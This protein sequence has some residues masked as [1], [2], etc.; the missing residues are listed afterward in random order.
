MNDAD[1]QSIDGRFLQ[2][3]EAAPSAPR[4]AGCQM[5]LPVGARFCLNCGQPVTGR[6]P[7]A[8]THFIPLA[9][10]APPPL[11]EKVR[12]AAYL[13][14]ERR[15]VTAVYVDVVGSTGLAGQL[16]SAGWSAVLDKMC[17]WF[18]PIIYR[19]E[20]TIARFV[21]DE[22]LAFFGAP[23]AHED[24]PVRAVRAALQILDTVAQGAATIRRKFGVDF[25]VRISVSTGPVTIGPVGRDLQF[26]YS[27]LEGSLNLA[28]QLEA[29]KRSMAVLIS[30]ETYR[31][32]APFF[33]CID[34]G[35]AAVEGRTETPAAA[36]APAEQGVH[37]YQVHAE[38]SRSVSG[39]GAHT[40]QLG[41]LEGNESPLVE[42]ESE[43]QSLLQLTEAVTAGL[44]RAVVIMGESGL[45]KTRLVAE[46]K[47]AVA[48]TTPVSMNRPN[49][50]LQWA[51]GHCL[52]Y[53]QGTAYHL[54]RDL[55]RSLIG[56]SAAAN[57][58][59]TRAALHALSKQLFGD[60][61]LDVYPYLGHL[62]SL[63]L[64][65]EA[66]QRILPLDPPELQAQYLAALKR[67]LVALAAAGPIVLL[68]EDLQWADPSS[69]AILSQLLPLAATT[70]LLFCL[71][72]TPHG[73]TAG[74]RLVTASR[75]TL[76]GRFIELR[77]NLLSEAGSR[78]MISN[79]LQI[80]AAPGAE[81]FVARWNLVLKKAEGNPLFIEEVLR[82]MI[83]R[84]AI[85]RRNGG[86]T[87]AGE[88]SALGIPDNLHGL[89]LARLDRLPDDARQTLRIA[90]VIGRRFPVRVLEQVL[91]SGQGETP[92]TARLIGYLGDLESSGLIDVFQI[93][94]ELIYRFHNTLLREA[95]YESLLP[96]DRQR[97]HL[98]VGEAMER[99]HPESLQQIAVQLAQHFLIGGDKVRALNYFSLAG[100]A[101]LN[102][103]ANQEAVSRYRQALDLLAPGH[104]TPLYGPSPQ[105]ANLLD[106]L[107]LALFWQG[108][109]QDA[110]QVWH[111]G[112]AL[113][114]EL[115]D[116][117]GV[118][119]LYARSARAAWSAG[120]TPGG[121]SLCQEALAALLPV[122]A[123]DGAPQNPG[124][125][126]LLHEAARAY[127]FNG[128][129]AEARRL[130]QQALE[131]AEYLGDISVQA[132]ALATLGLLSDQPPEEALDA[133]SKAAEL[134]ESTGLLSQAARAHVNLAALMATAMPDFAAARD[135]YQRAAEL[136]R[137]RGN[138]AG[139]LLALGGMTGVL[140]ESGDLQEAEATLLA[141]RKLLP[142]APL[143]P[144]ADKL[145]ADP[146]PAGF[147]FLFNEALL[148]RY[149]G[150]F[151]EAAQMLHALQTGERRRG[152]LQN[153]VDV[154]VHLAELLLESHILPDLAILGE[155]SDAE[156]T[157][158]EAVEICDRWSTC[159]TRA[160]S[161]LSM[162]YT[163]QGRYADA[164]RLLSET[165]DK[166]GTHP[167]AFDEGWPFLAE[168]RLAAAEARWPQALALFASVAEV[169]G[170]LGM[171]W[172]R[173]RVL[174]AWAEAHISRR[175]PTDVEQARTLLQ[176]AFSLFSMM[177]ASYYTNLVKDRLR[178]LEIESYAQALAHQKVDQEMAAA[179]KIQSGFLPAM[180]PRIPGWQLAAVLV[181]SRQTSGDFYDFIPL[182]DGRL[183][184]VIADVADKGASAA[185]FTAL[186]ISLIRTYAAGYENR[187]DL[188]LA[189]TNRRILADTHTD[190]FVT[191]FY[192]VLD[193][194][195][196]A[197]LYSNAGH[198]PP[199]HFLGSIDPLKSAAAG[200][201]AAQPLARTGIPVGIL[202]DTT[203]E[204]KT[205]QLTA[206]DVL[207]LYTDGVTDAQDGQGAFFSSERLLATVNA[208]TSGSE[209][210]QSHIDGQPAKASA[211]EIQEAILTA[212]HQFS[213]GVPQ[214]DDIALVVLRRTPS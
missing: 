27:A 135:H 157:L 52:S 194:L 201:S 45:G 112:I 162:V 129:Q 106:K 25:A 54:L 13:T 76:G 210:A 124:M 62:L 182:S 178:T 110:L 59:E 33:D 84:G 90:A 183:G 207:V 117:D 51:E 53:S 55:L 199:Y 128:L 160:R 103:Y 39:A 102:A 81:D 21:D 9:A 165:W 12:A 196:G 213:G 212:I 50:S 167:F 187:P 79:L 134:A 41:G 214:F 203:W 176:E 121:L 19:Y 145:V 42:R 147:H 16:G 154:N 78:Q 198:N 179:G 23:V 113:F 48:Q 37:I 58:P 153:L 83:D 136:H 87:T 142:E 4:C 10:A 114:Q 202:T 46:W 30:E 140:L 5:L 200:S 105:H 28:A 2:D 161:F 143:L 192:G 31:L 44:G 125:A 186:S 133:L 93:K 146:G 155:W 68:L 15:L 43:L 49:P 35:P 70:P 60:L 97:L 205:V 100:D 190:L 71:V 75:E 98:A 72:I 67:L 211:Q 34:I 152:N 148:R 6:T 171:R 138:T 61:F 89:L 91:G 209:A 94:P 119:R 208:V 180:P 82:M 88:I 151:V 137:L 36:G 29:T 17:D 166:A 77:L 195:S 130:G 99:L 156:A 66:A 92:T 65:D 206:G 188:V 108:H 177:D 144:E 174:L 74:W 181:P 173:A 63:E 120:D 40:G 139:E 159:S 116:S 3:R 8:E 32:V 107:G 149:R 184:I 11:V 104:G 193:P 96:I 204:M 101:A 185:L 7:T 122:D 86:W 197:L 175:E 26:E 123:I 118:A 57:E 14:G 131:M 158:S 132:E 115:G 141:I 24:D 164:R 22:L 64:E 127:L 80:D 191:I 56:V 85:K 95:V 111:E 109:F 38:R 69:V 163:S 73:D 170:R 126:L 172:Q 47:K 189:E 168:A 20:G 1:H 150:D 169:F 18:C